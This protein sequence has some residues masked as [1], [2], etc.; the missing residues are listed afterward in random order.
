MTTRAIIDYASDEQGAEMRDALYSAIQDKVMA[1]I[2]Y[3]IE[4]PFTAKFGPDTRVN[5]YGEISPNKVLEWLSNK[6][7]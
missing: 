5:I 7:V 6:S 3:Y 1:H 4:Q 2:E